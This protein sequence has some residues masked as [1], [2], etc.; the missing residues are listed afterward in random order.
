MASDDFAATRDVPSDGWFGA[1]S[2][3]KDSGYDF[4]DWLSAYDDSDA[5]LAV[6]TRVW[7][8]GDRRGV[9][10]RT[11]VARDGG[12]LPTLT[13]L[14]G[15]AAWHER[16]TAEM[17]GIYFV[18]HPDPRPLLLPDGFDGHPLRKEFVLAS[19]VAKEWPGAKEPGESVAG[20]K[21]PPGV[22]AAGAWGP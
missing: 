9:M 8:V 20:R 22:P 21:R 16:E 11:R 17:F 5:G 7:S 14:W 15:G 18:D 10:L 4:F 13:S 6:V 19:R 1:A 2:E 3:L 12:S